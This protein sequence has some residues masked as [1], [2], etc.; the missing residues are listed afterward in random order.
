MTTWL[1]LNIV[2][3]CPNHEL[4]VLTLCY[5][6]SYLVT[7]SSQ[8]I[9]H[10]LNIIALVVSLNLRLWQKVKWHEQRLQKYLNQCLIRD[11]LVPKLVT[12][13]LIIF[14]IAKNDERFIH[15]MLKIY[16]KISSTS[17]SLFIIMPSC[18]ILLLLLPK[19]NEK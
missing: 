6:V 1:N 2:A 3:K 14:G 5:L 15:T 12:Y 8:P 9:F 7:C 13:K 19:M 4:H 18:K 17:V 10:L 11:T 16:I